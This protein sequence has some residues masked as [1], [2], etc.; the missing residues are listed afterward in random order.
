MK[1]WKPDLYKVPHIIHAVLEVLL[2]DV[3]NKIL[4]QTLGI[5]YSYERKF[6]QA[7]AIYLK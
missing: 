5:L 3:E 6:D 7:L 1:D 4:L 2:T